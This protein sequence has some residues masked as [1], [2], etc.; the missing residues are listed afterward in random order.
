M[1]SYAA[2]LAEV[3][4]LRETIPCAGVDI[5]PSNEPWNPVAA[6]VIRQVQLPAAIRPRTVDL[7]IPIP[8]LYGFAVSAGVAITSVPL[9][10]ETAD[11]LRVVPFCVPA[12]HTTLEKQRGYFVDV[13]ENYELLLQGFS[14]CVT[15]ADMPEYFVH[16]T[17]RQMVE[18]LLG[19]LGSPTQAV[20]EELARLRGLVETNGPSAFLLMSI[21]HAHEGLREYDRAIE[22]LD[23]AT[24]LYPDDRFI[25]KKKEHI[26]GL[27]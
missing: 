27:M 11:G 15:P 20:R 22:V 6:V 23:D 18:F 7:R 14:T 25:V 9:M 12:E 24:S 10:E 26:R 13:R 16:I 2:I 19:F 21:A 4:E 1:Q 17:L 5:I 3:T 8:N